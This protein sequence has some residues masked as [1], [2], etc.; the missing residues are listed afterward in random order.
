M[1][2]NGLAWAPE[3]SDNAFHPLPILHYLSYFVVPHVICR[4]VAQDCGNSS[5]VSAF[6]IMEASS[7]AGEH[8]HLDRDDDDEIDTI[9]HRTTIALKRTAVDK[10]RDDLETVAAKALVSLQGGEVHKPDKPVSI[11]HFLTDI[12]CLREYRSQGQS[13][14]SSSAHQNHQW[15]KQK[16]TRL[17]GT[18]RSVPPES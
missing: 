2:G 6:S 4:L 14:D 13:H 9:N 17:T 16:I 15:T 7:D 8:I 3:S 18:K 12:Y 11:V 1:Y 10:Q 5:D